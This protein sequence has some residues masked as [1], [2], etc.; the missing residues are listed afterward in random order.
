MGLGCVGVGLM[1]GAVGFTA[2][3]WFVLTI[4]GSIKVD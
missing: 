2:S 3:F 4:Y 1:C